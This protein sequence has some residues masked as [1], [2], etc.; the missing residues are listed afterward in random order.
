[1]FSGFTIYAPKKGM[2]IYKR[3]WDGKKVTTDQPWVFGKTLWLPYKFVCH[4]FQNLCHEIDISKV[5]VNQKVEIGIDAFS[6]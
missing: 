3:D 5:L 6:W 1:M 4:D 2:V